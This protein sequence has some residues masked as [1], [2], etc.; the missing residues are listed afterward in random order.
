MILPPNSCH[1]TKIRRGCFPGFTLV[2][3]MV[4]VVII[5]LLAAIAIPTVTR[6]RRRAQNSR[7]V[8]DLRAFSQAFDTYAT[9]Y[10]KWP[11]NAG[12]GIVPAGMSGELRDAAWSATNSLG[13]RWNWDY[14]NFGVTAGISTIGVKV[15]DDQ[16][17]EIDAVIDDGNLNSGHFV[18]ASDGRYIYVLVK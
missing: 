15:G 8:S 9:K 11:P 12:T 6:L 10:G 16:M 14:R 7:F 4:V 18:K 5:G 13:G 1:R 3:I 2:E 17:A